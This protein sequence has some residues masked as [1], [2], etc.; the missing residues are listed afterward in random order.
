MGTDHLVV[1]AIKQELWGQV[2]EALSVRAPLPKSD[3]L[4]SQHLG[5]Q[6][7]SQRAM[8]TSNDY[9]E[10]AERCTE[11]AGESFEPIVAEALRALASDY[12]TRAATL[13]DRVL[14]QPIDRT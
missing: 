14:V 9:K 10:L 1:P 13:L 11:L 6:P 12:L 2:R 4:S 8:L 3:R 5:P 7:W